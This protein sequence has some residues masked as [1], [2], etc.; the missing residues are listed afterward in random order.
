MLYDVFY[1]EFD[2]G[3]GCP[4]LEWAALTADEV[5]RF[6]L[7]LEDAA[8]SHFLVTTHDVYDAIDYIDGE[9]WLVSRF[10]LDLAA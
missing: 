8:P 4:H 2:Y 5:D 7:N 9:E 1:E 10:H 3:I 6:L